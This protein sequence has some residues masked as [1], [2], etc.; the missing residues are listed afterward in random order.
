MAAKGIDIYRMM[1]IKEK[2]IIKLN[3]K[4]QARNINKYL[5]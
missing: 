3:M 1:I 5:Q 2:E 4:L